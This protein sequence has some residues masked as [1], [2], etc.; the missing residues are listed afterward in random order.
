M[1]IKDLF[2]DLITNTD[3]FYFIFYIEDKDFLIS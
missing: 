3:L 1:K 2:F